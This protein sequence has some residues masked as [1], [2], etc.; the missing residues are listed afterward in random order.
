M[1]DILDENRSN[2]RVGG[3]SPCGILGTGKCLD[4][5]RFFAKCVIKLFRIENKM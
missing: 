3:T 1:F 5:G 4:K 2:L